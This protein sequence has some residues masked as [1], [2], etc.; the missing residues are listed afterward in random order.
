MNPSTAVFPL[1]QMSR[2]CVHCN[3][4]ACSGGITL[5]H[6]FITLWQ[7][8]SPITVTTPSATANTHLCR[9][10]DKF[11]LGIQRDYWDVELPENWNM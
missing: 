8:Y 6:A 3:L 4:S 1:F 2:C 5:H 7:G 9:S 10:R 11:S